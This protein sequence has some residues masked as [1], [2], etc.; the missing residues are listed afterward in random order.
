SVFYI[1]VPLG[2]LGT[3]MAL[4]FIVEP[5]K[6]IRGLAN[7]DIIGSILLGISLGSMVLVLDQG[8]SWGWGDIRSVISYIVSAVTLIIF[9]FVEQLGNDQ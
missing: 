9:I 1:N 3:F 8:Q 6:E 2:I 7:F 5:V 4:R